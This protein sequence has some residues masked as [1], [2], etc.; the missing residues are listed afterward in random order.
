[1]TIESNVAPQTIALIGFGEAGT[2]IA[3]GLCGPD[4]WR[5]ITR[6]GDNRARR[7]IAIDTALDSDDRG[8]AL[9]AEA[10][11]LDV[12]ITRDYTAA[13]RA[14][15]LVVC[16]VPG[17]N[18]LAA[19][20]AAAPFLKP[21]ALYLD[22]CTVTGRMAEDDRAVVAAA[23]ARYVD[24]AVMGTFFGHGHKAPMILAG[25]D[26]AAVAAWMKAQGFVVSMLGPKPGSASAVKM[27]RSV[28]IKGI[29][30]LAV[31]SFVAARRQGILEEV[32]DCFGDLD[33]VT[34]RQYVTTLLETHLVHAKRR[35]EEMELVERTLH[36]TGVEPLMTRA[37]VANHRRTVEAAIAPADGK[38][39]PLDVA[40]ELL[41][42]QAVRG[43]HNAANK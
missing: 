3:R 37:I 42:R 31:E 21:D 11:R 25:P 35:W 38:V 41:S 33:L 5:G 6:P 39:P 12:D 32:L 29:E 43:G 7:V 16:A 26:A 19:A 15:D 13:L 14:A 40:L 8:H 17:E 1:M 28:M 34:F 24:V 2:A 23:G 30:A 9:G 18:A 27:M 36:E 20:T 4:G 22:L 10:R